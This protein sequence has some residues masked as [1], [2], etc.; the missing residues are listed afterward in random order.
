MTR[1]CI[2]TRLLHTCLLHFIPYPPG[3]QHTRNITAAAPS[4]IPIGSS[5]PQIVTRDTLIDCDTLTVAHCDTLIVLKLE[6]PPTGG[7]SHHK[8]GAVLRRHPHRPTLGS[9]CCAP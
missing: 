1:L 2:G 9:H 7:Y 4:W 8:R 6:Q 5:L 3:G